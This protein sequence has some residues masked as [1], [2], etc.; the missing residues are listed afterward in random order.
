[1]ANGSPLSLILA[2]KVADSGGGGSVTPASVLT[3]MDEM[4]ESQAADALDAIGG[5]AAPTKVTDLSSTSITLASA[6]DNTVY[7][8]G[9]LSSLTIPA[10]PASGSFVIIFISG[11]TPTTTS[12]PVTMKFPTANGAMD[13]CAANTRYEINVVDGYALAVGWPTT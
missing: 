12:F 6:A 10:I 11:S 13:A 9:E 2:G 3:A 8:Y 1:M 5:E 4:S 7:E